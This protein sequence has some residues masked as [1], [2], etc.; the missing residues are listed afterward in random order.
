MGSLNVELAT[1]YL[2]V[3]VTGG[4]VYFQHLICRILLEKLKRCSHLSLDQSVFPQD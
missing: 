4:L 2:H 3:L 1:C